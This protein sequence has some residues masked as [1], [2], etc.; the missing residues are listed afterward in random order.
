MGLFFIL[1]FM[2]L[3]VQ[4]DIGKGFNEFFAGFL[5]QGK[6]Y[7]QNIVSNF[8]PKVNDLLSNLKVNLLK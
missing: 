5:V 8:Y 3:K 2:V 4:S 1:P 6:F 7:V